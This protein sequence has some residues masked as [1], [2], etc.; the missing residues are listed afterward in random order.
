[1][2]LALRKVLVILVGPVGVLGATAPIGSASIVTQASKAST[3]SAP[4]VGDHWHIAWGVYVCDK[5]IKLPE[6]TGNDP[7]GIHTHGDG[8][9]HAHPFSEKAAGKNATLARFFETENIK[10]GNKLSFG[11]A[12]QEIFGGPRYKEVVKEVEEAPKVTDKYDFLRKKTKPNENEVGY[13]E[14]Y[15][16]TGP[17]L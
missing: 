12:E 9:I 17:S 10:V 4:R 1:M 13:D 14:C 6:P 16:N 2:K 7:V 5:F 11:V 8:L 3:G 15:V